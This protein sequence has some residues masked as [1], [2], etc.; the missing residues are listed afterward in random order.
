M[1]ISRTLAAW[2]AEPRPLAE[3]EALKLA[4]NAMIDIVGCMIAGAPDVAARR[5]LEAVRDLGSGP[6]SV[7]GSDVM[8][9]APLAALVNGTAA[10][11]L[12][13]DDN[14]HGNSG[15]A[16]AVLAPALL[17]LGEERQSS[18]RAVLDAY[19]SGLEAI[20]VV[21][22]GVNIA[23][24]VK[25]W[26]TTST[27]GVIGAAAAAARL[28][29]LDAAGVLG[30][31]SL[32]FSHASGSKLQFGT[33]AKPFHAGMAAKN[34]LMAARYAGTGLSAVEEP[35]DGPWSFR[36][37]YIGEDASPGYDEA[38]QL[39]GP[40]LAIERFG[41][42]VKVHPDCASTHCAVDGVL[43]LMAEHDLAAADVARVDVQVNKISYD[44]LMF[45]APESEM[46][47]RFSMEYA[48]ALAVTKGRLKLADFRADGIHD[49][50]VRAWLANVAMT[51]S[52]ADAPLPTAPNGREPAKVT[53][54]A[55]DGRKF[56]R[57]VQHA[58]GVLQNPLSDAEMW[59]K[60]DDCVEGV[61]APTAAAEVRA[62]LERFE[63]LTNVAELMRLLRRPNQRR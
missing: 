4:R 20:L 15:H 53:L 2:M 21:G 13:F 24:Y 62:A 50:D 58:K 8:L 28:A 40:P 56:E 22:A 51:E 31:I 39:L 6:A 30:A 46:E 43:G 25:G 63:A 23:H 48:I 32:G 1:T 16:T 29:G 37:L 59:E 27:I 5:T 3:G 10:H 60:F 54:H 14:Y 42:K 52:P 41:L 47:A 49:P 61:I 26:H 12:D 35:L 44:N 18:G 57:F 34:A 17:A 9:S 45:P 36:D 11:A 7:V 33:M 55:A 19:I 38:A